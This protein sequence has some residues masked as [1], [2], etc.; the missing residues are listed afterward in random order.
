MKFTT[1]EYK[2][3]SKIRTINCFKGQSLSL[4]YEDGYLTDTQNLCS[5]AYPAL[6]TA[7][8]PKAYRTSL[9]LVNPQSV[10][11]DEKLFYTDSNRFIYDNTEC[12]TLETADKKK[13]AALDDTVVIFPDRYAY[14][15]KTKY[16]HFAYTGLRELTN[17]DAITHITPLI[18]ISDTAPATALEGDKYYNTADNTVNTL[19]G[20]VWL[21]SEPSFT[22]TYS[23]EENVFS[24]LLTT[25]VFTTLSD[26]TL[27]FETVDA[28]G[29]S[30]NSHI[31]IS[32]LK[33]GEP[34][35]PDLSGFKAGDKIT[36]RG[37]YTGSTTENDALVALANGTTITT[38][39]GSY[40]IVE[41]TGGVNSISLALA[42]RVEKVIMT[43][44]IPP[45]ECLATVGDRIWGAVGNIIYACAPNKPD[46]WSENNG[47]VILE[48][49]TIGN[50]IGC[51]GL[52]GTPVFF[53]DSAIIKVLSVYNGY[54][55]SVTPAP[56]LSPNSP[57]SIAYASGAL[58]YVSD[59]GIM[60]FAGNTPQ[61][62]NFDCGEIAEGAIGASDRVKYYLA[63]DSRLYVYD[64]E[65]DT[66]H[67]R[68]INV[69]DM[70]DFGTSI[71]VIGKIFE[72][73]EILLLG[74]KSDSGEIVYPI[75]EFA[76][77][78]TDIISKKTYSKLYI[79]LKSDSDAPLYITVDYGDGERSHHSIMGTGKLTL[80]SVNLIPHR[81][82]SLKVTLYSSSGNFILKSISREFTVYEN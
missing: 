71:A 24:S 35:Y 43:K 46:E 55:L 33:E 26:K 14:S 32:F 31:K 1:P 52:A 9:P 2:E 39:R 23:F 57:D 5:D 18:A 16:Y 74:S 28:N 27:K 37:L 41:N 65:N 15:H 34:R 40:M 49:D 48:A 45:L 6:K 19:Q 78:D 63:S 12:G 79:E 69:T 76:P 10:G 58:Y 61:K 50:I 11:A 80:Y 62:V 53:T 59:S 20:G 21:P 42:Q 70:T 51:A 13:F 72:Q 38:L 7:D 60:R 30:G 22:T 64:P 77:W 25:H 67:Y 44:V 75:A 73:T 68:M 3:K 36:L 4:A 29:E 54:K 8:L 81:C 47:A 82:D 17:T 66:W 56:G